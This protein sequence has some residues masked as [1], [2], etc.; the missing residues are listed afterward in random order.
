M[1]LFKF[2]LSFVVVLSSV[3][4]YMIAAPNLTFVGLALLWVGGFCVTAAA[5]ALNQILEREY[6]AQMVRTAGRPVAAGRMTVSTALICAGMLSLVGFVI[7]SAFNPL[8][9]FLGMVALISYAFLYTPLK[10][11]TP[12][13]VVVGAF[14]GA[15]PVIIGVTAAVGE[16]TTLAVAL[17]GIQFLW[18]FA[19]F[20]AIAWL[21]DKDYK[22]AGFV[23]LPSKSGKKD[24]S[25]GLQSFV[26]SIL[27]IPFSFLPWV[28]GHSSFIAGIMA[29]VLAVWYC[30]KG[31]KFFIDSDDRS[32]R[33][34]M[35]ASFL[36]LPLV[37]VV[38][39]FD[40]IWIF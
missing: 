34:L 3:F 27:L 19:H 21:S 39:L 2:R 14:P 36:Y 38:Y 9:G 29:A 35:F 37:L 18:Q 13:A 11:V 7:L 17:F 40:T 12:F 6:D 1:L 20:W 22:S 4:A 10:R 30:W 24:S 32:A 23:L 15:L 33:K 31:W 25:V 8:T 5:N 28:I 16:I 26:Y